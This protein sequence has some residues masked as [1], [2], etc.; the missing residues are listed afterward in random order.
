MK[1]IILVG[2]VLIF[3]IA[4]ARPEYQDSQGAKPQT[5]GRISI[6]GYGGYVERITDNEAGVVCWVLM[7]YEKGGIS[8]LPLEQTK[9]SKE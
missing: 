4:C 6:D 8:C 7:G 2:L 5:I 1:R 9:L 3:M